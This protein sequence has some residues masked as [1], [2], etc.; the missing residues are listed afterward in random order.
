MSLWLLT[1]EHLSP[2]NDPDW[3]VIE[4]YLTQLD[5][6]KRSIVT[7]RRKAMGELIVGGGNLIDNEVLYH[8]GYSY[9]VDDDLEEG[10][11]GRGN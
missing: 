11:R 4:E 8:V 7:L 9:I 6:Q 10:R 5:G 1:P 3:K 2:I